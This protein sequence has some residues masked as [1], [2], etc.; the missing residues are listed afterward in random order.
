VVCTNLD[1]VLGND[2][3]ADQHADVGQQGE[4]GEDAE[5]P[6]EYQKPQDGQEGEHVESRVYGGR[7]NYRF[8][9]VAADGCAVNSFYY[10]RKEWEKTRRKKSRHTADSV[11]SP[12]PD[13]LR[14]IGGAQAS[15]ASFWFC[16]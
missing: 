8:V 12:K 1:D 14:R 11:P 3:Q 13:S 9:L 6:D 15:I 4:D 5:V 10:L 7:Q 16:F 2:D